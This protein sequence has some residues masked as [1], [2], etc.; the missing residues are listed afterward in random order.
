VG[1]GFQL[2]LTRFEC[3]RHGIS[4][5]E[6]CSRL[7]E[8]FVQPPKDFRYAGLLGADYHKVLETHGVAHVY[9]HWSHM[10]PLA[11]QHKRM[12]SFTAPFTVLRLL[13]RLKISYEAARKRAEPYNK[14]EGKLPEMRRDTVNLVKKAVAEKRRTY[15]LVNNRAEGNAPLTVAALVDQLQA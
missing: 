10:P 12:E 13:T 8:F 9:N 5:E 7:D 11:E 1:D 15:V 2:G 3:Q 4:G 6:F 14:I